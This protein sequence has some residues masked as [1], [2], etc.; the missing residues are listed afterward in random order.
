MSEYI[1]VRVS[2]CGYVV[3]ERKHKMYE[4]ITVSLDRNEILHVLLDIKNKEL[5]DYSELTKISILDRFSN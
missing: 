5:E 3:A 4:V 2:L 1:I